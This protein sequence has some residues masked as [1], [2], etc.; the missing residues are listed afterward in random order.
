MVRA[1]QVLNVLSELFVWCKGKTASNGTRHAL[2]SNVRGLRSTLGS[3]TI[4][5]WVQH[6]ASGTIRLKGNSSKIYKDIENR[7]CNK[8]PEVLSLFSGGYGTLVNGGVFDW[9]VIYCFRPFRLL[10]ICV[11]HSKIPRTKVLCVLSP[12]Q[13]HVI[14]V[15][16]F[17]CSTTRVARYTVRTHHM[18]GVPFL[19][20]L[21]RPSFTC[22][23][24][25][26]VST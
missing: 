15:L 14:P 17:N 12:K 10:C 6:Q 25:N 19:V 8:T 11:S 1:P 20:S 9:D 4:G 22:C 23:N 16:E 5:H 2:T 7:N 26:K 21:H 24:R 18:P 13:V 3:H